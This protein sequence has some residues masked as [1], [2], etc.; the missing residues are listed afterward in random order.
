M[1]YNIYKKFEYYDV[2]SDNKWFDYCQKYQIP[3]ITI[4][5]KN[6]FADIEFDCITFNNKAID[7]VLQVNENKI[8]VKTGEIYN[9]FKNKKSQFSQ[10]G[11]CVIKFYDLNVNAAEDAAIEIFELIGSIVESANVRI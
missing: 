9:K 11:W 5:Q 7:D 1:N 10:S 8:R 6:S 3:Y 2:A 4:L